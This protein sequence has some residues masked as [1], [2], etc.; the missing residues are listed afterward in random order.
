MRRIFSLFSFLIFSIFNFSIFNFNSLTFDF[1][2]LIT[3]NNIYK[4]SFFKRRQYFNGPLG[5]YRG[6][7]RSPD[8]NRRQDRRLQK[9]HHQ[10]DGA[11]DALPA[12]VAQLAP[13]RGLDAVHQGKPRRFYRKFIF[14]L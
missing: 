4:R 12:T 14:I 11:G 5:P 3:D 7:S 2:F 13:R 8:S 10:R 6:V 9:M 1:N